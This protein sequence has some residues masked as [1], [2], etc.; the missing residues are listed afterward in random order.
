MNRYFKRNFIFT[1]SHYEEWQSGHC[2]NQ[3]HISCV[4]T[5]EF[6]G[7]LMRVFLSNIEELRIHK[8]FEFEMEGS[9]ILDDRIQYVHYTSDYN[10]LVPIVCHLFFANG[11]INCV[12][13][14]MTNPDR[15]IEF[16][17][18]LEKLDQQS[19]HHDECTKTLSTAQGI[20]SELKSYGML[21]LAP[22]MERAV[23]LYNTNSN[24]H[25][26]EQARS[27]VEA[28]KLFVKCN[29]L[30]LQDHKGNVSAYR[31]KI[32]MFIALCNYKINNIDRAYK[33][34]HKALHAIDDAISDSPIA[35]IPR[36]V[37]GEE[38]I[39][40]LISVIEQKYI[41]LIDRDSNYN[42]IDENAIDTTFIDKLSS[43][44][45]QNISKELI[46]TLIDT[47][48]NIQDEFSKIGKIAGSSTI[49]FEN[50]QILEIYKVVLYFAWE[51]Y[52]YGWH[53]DFWDEGDSTLEYTMFEI[54]PTAIINDLIKSLKK[55]SPFRMIERNGMITNELIVIY[56][57]L[58]RKINSG[59]IQI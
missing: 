41:D 48:S 19:S 59:K 24:V 26:L 16:Y 29:E 53:S 17:G 37:Y 33:I 3:G 27:I 25:N 55:S 7:D 39:N 1:A 4:I 10:P 6:S 52:N 22:L 43:N 12:R 34:A 11:T 20:M 15:I 54:Q 49:V 14:A 38:T 58:I 46:K 23:K 21:S 36:S 18:R 8:N 5:A 13:F 45:S 30:D 44:M 40:N 56:E 35:G 2:L 42:E 31:P 9:M 51:K 47:I 50:N 57:D 28:L 32:L